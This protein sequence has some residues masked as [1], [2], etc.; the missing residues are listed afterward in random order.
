MVEG[1]GSVYFT[2]LAGSQPAVS[3]LLIGQVC[4]NVWEAGPGPGV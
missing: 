2:V 1:S 3:M 4:Q